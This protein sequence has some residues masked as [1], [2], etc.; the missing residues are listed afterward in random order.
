M[1]LCLVGRSR[2]RNGSSGQLAGAPGVVAPAW[3]APRWQAHWVSAQFHCASG[4]GDSGRPTVLPKGG[5]RCFRQACLPRPFAPSG[6]GRLPHPSHEEARRE[7]VARSCVL[8]R[9]CQNQVLLPRS[10]PI[11]LAF[12]DLWRGA[13]TTSLEPETNAPSSCAARR[14]RG[15]LE[16]ERP[17]PLSI[18]TGTSLTSTSRP[19]HSAV[20]RRYCSSRASGRWRR[21]C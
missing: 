21:W 2:H 1:R 6:F 15:N 20:G 3:W 11:G 8:R 4:F 12:F 18:F 14:A 5:M 7:N 19:L 9:T 10:C 13:Q 16:I 17:R